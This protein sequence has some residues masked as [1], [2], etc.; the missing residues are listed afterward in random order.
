MRLAFAE[1]GERFDNRFRVGA[2]RIVRFRVDTPHDTGRVEHDDGRMG[3]AVAKSA[4]CLLLVEDTEGPDDFRLWIGQHREPDLPPLREAAQR[5]DRVIADGGDGVAEVGDLFEALV[6]GDRLDLAEGSPVEGSRE[7]DDQTALPRQVFP[8][9]R[10]A[11]LI[12]HRQCMRA[13]LS[14]RGTTIRRRGGQS[15]A[16]PQQQNR[17]KSGQP[18][19]MQI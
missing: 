13:R 4:G 17:K 8:A 11:V 15:Q 14:D 16:K 18:S 7:Q 2:L 6:P 19:L 12:L 5:V 9:S 10:V 3:N 1:F